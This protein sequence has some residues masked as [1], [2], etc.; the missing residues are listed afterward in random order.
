VQ[1]NSLI[2][3]DMRKIQLLLISIFTCNSLFA[4]VSLPNF[5]GNNMV[6]QRNKPIP[7]W[8]WANA[9]EKITVQFDHQT[10]TTKADK[11]GKWMVKLDNENA[12][13]PYVLTI[14]GKNT[15][16]FKNVLVG[17]VWI[18]SGQ[19]NM[20]MPIEGWGKVNN[21]EKEIAA[22]N[23]PM[24]RHIKVPSTVSSI[25]Q[26]NI[27]AADWKIC[28]PETAGDFTAA[29]FFFARELYNK[30]KVP[31]GLIN[32]SWGGTM[33][34]TWTSRKAFENSDEF[35][36]MIAGMPLLNLDSMANVKKEESIKRIEALQGSIDNT[37]AATWNEPG[38]NDNAWPLM[39]LPNFW[40]TQQL[41]DLDGIVWFRKTVTVSAEDAG[42]AA[43][44]EL[45]MIDDNDVTYV[46]GIKAGSTNGYNVK[47]NYSV[48]A[49]VL[50]E[51]KNVIAVRVDD[52]GGYGGIYGDSAD[53]KL[54]IGNHT[55]PLNGQWHFKVEKITG[56]SSSIGPNSYPTLLFN[57]M[58]NPLIPF[59][60]R[61]VIWYQ[62]EAN[63]DRA[64][65]YRKAFPLMITDWRKCWA[66]SDF[67][68]YFVQLASFNAANGTSNNG[69]TWAELR[70]AQ[71][72]TLSLPNTGMAVITD[73]GDS[74]NIH[75]KDKQDVGKR[76]AAIALHNVYGENN[77]YNGPVYTTMKTEGNKAIIS[78]I[79]SGLAVHDKYGYIKGFEIAGTDKQFHYAKAYIS[80]NT[81]VAYN[82]VVN[83]PVAVRYGW[84]D[85]AGDDN[86]FN[87]EGFP[88]G[89]F[90]TD[91]WTGIT[92]GVKYE[93]GK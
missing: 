80:G 11:A 8:G 27:P 30:L 58:I 81:V 59:A 64:Y 49:G 71:V 17:E 13:G 15:V 35:K 47:R 73:I 36:D 29:G 46:N 75:P 72:K 78:F 40:E 34:E 91:D 65:Q 54:T 66:N 22:A 4:N 9:G 77:V 51:G 79:G 55:M 32:S 89:P 24:I 12:G 63:A 69:S 62:G 68:F 92:E 25:P 52:T 84:T 23:Y 50:K 76:L 5:F 60:F 3:E 1:N 53:M 37:D 33:V 48:A 42:K 16:I 45:A 82:D 2:K 43:T 56:G 18:C 57:A 39:Q 87:N 19:S 38:T 90:R 41:G 26:D 61:G 31:I 70:E 21:Y 7:V 10:K 86:L 83:T 20:E 44:L 88:A 28:S 6:L 85:D 14:K 67:P 93:V 74:S